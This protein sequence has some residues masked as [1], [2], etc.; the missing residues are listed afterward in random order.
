[1][2]GKI[3]CLTMLPGIVNSNATFLRKSAIKFQFVIFF[4]TKNIKDSLD[5][6][7]VS[8]YWQKGGKYP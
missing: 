3:T 5:K 8:Y 1:M 6:Y 2:Q 4:F 7:L